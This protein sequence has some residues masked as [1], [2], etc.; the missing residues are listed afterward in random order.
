[1]IYA[2]DNT[3]R[4]REGNIKYEIQKNALIHTDGFSS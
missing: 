2:E 3:G 1:M 4:N